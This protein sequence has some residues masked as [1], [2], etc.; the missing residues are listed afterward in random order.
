MLQCFNAAL[1]ILKR[2]LAKDDRFM[3]DAGGEFIAIIK[4][5]EK[6]NP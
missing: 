5:L 2:N 1:L 4:I 6:L 3:L